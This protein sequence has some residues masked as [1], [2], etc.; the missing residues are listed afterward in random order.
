[1]Y[2]KDLKIIHKSPRKGDLRFSQASISLAKKEL[3]YLPKF[4]LKKGLTKM[5]RENKIQRKDL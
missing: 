2:G 1:M 3:N 5:L 4:S